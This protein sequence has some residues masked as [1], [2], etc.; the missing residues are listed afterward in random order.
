ML[1]VI[2]ARLTSLRKTPCA[3]LVCLLTGIG[4]GLRQRI[5]QDSLGAEPMFLVVPIF[6]AVLQVKMVGD[7]GHLIR[8]KVW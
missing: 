5:F 6:A 2:E 1:R 8:G 3:V 7:G 4:G